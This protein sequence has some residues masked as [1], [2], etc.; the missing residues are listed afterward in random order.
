[1]SLFS[2]KVRIY[3]VANKGDWY[4]FGFM[5]GVSIIFGGSGSAAT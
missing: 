4:D 5:L 1:V 2:V 3:E